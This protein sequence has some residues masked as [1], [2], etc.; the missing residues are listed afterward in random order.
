MLESARD[1][2]SPPDKFAAEIMLAAMEG[3]MRSLLEAGSS[4]SPATVRKARE[5]FVLLCQSNMAAATAK[6][7]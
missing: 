6:R 1:A 5:Q 3:A 2:K 4:P 7:V